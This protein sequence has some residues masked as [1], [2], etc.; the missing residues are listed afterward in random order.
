MARARNIKPG[1]F[2]NE[3]LVELDMATRLLFIGLWTIADR[4]G[5][6]EDRPKR[7]KMQVFP[8]DDVDIDDSLAKLADRGFIQRYEVD[9]MQNIQIVNWKK[10]QSPHI[11]ETA[12][13]IPAPD[14][15][16]DSDEE[17][18]ASTGQ[19]PDEHPA[20][21][22]D[23]LIPDS[24]IPDSGLSDSEG[25]A[26]APDPP[27]PDPPPE[28]AKPK[29]VRPAPKPRSS[30]IAED[31]AVNDAMRQWADEAGYTPHFVTYETEKFR[32]YY[33]SSPKT[34]LDWP[35]TWRNWL[36][37]SAESNPQAVNRNA[38]PSPAN[39]KPFPSRYETP[40]DRTAA[41]FDT[42][43]A[44][45]DGVPPDPYADHEVI[46]VKVSGS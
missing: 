13:T 41:A 22:P 12:S 18:G 8:A 1:F 31:F 15:T 38:P 45:L 34:Y 4:E 2:S 16:G 3:E 43:F 27:T 32:D 33:A 46:D 7:I 11:K 25:G 10:H 21:R 23:S 6:M 35:A 19:A 17:S 29:T 26:F 36:R 44:E 24:L 14:G 28:P 39:V 42:F 30:R 40:A 5:R 37:R 9:G 20:S